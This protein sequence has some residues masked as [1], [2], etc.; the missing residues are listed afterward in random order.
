MKSM[1]HTSNISTIR[2]GERGIISR[3]DRDRALTTLTTKTK[4]V[5]IYK[6]NELEEPTL[7][8]F[9]SCPT[10]SK[11]TTISIRMTKVQDVINLT[12]K[13]TAT[14]NLVWTMFNKIGIFPIVMSYL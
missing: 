13:D 1:A 6:Q 12:L 9:S 4:M 10:S 7:L 8:D 14:N 2:I 11:V 5:S 3:R